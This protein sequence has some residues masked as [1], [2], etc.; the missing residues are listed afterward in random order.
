LFY[1]GF[2]YTV[3]DRVI[4]KSNP[5]SS[6]TWNDPPSPGQ[7]G[8][9]PPANFS[10]VDPQVILSG[11]LNYPGLQASTGNSLALPRGLTAAESGNQATTGNI[12]RIDIPGIP[13]TSGSLFYSFTAQLI[14]GTWTIRANGTGT[15]QAGNAGN[16]D[17]GFF[18]GFSPQSTSAEGMSLAAGFASQLRI[19]R[20][21]AAGGIQTGDGQSEYEL[22]IH[23]NNTAAVSTVAAWDTATTPA[24]KLGDTILIVGEYQFAAG[25]NND[26]TR[27]WINPVPGAAP[28][29]P[30]AESALGVDVIAAGL[31]TFYFRSDAIMPANFQVDEL[32]IGTTYADVT[33]TPEPS[34]LVLG[35][36]AVLC[37]GWQ[38]SSRRE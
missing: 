22:G 30:A 3:G 25:S 2:D 6:A 35:S 17:G 20:K 28:G 37:C 8:P 31:K 27:I 23:K 36:L 4:G 32:R 1:D 9:S 7:P 14:P 10:S 33:P 19:R 11:S 15:N 5:G 24:L 21:V 16:Q 13:Y 38:R 26:V 12:A 34:S 29:L 18:A